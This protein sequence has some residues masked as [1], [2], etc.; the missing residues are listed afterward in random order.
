MLISFVPTIAVEMIDT[1]LKEGGAK[2]FQAPYK[3]TRFGVCGLLDIS[4]FTKMSQTFGNIGSVGTEQ[5]IKVL[6][7]YFNQLIETLMEIDCD[8]LKFAGDALLLYWPCGQD[9]IKEAVANATFQLISICEKTETFSPATENNVLAASDSSERRGLLEQTI[10]LFCHAG[11]TVGD[12]TFHIL[13]GLHDRHEF[14]VSSP[15]LTTEIAD[16][17]EKSKVREVVV[18]P[19]AWE[20]IAHLCDF[21]ERGEGYHLVKKIDWKCKKIDGAV[22]ETNLS[23]PRAFALVRTFVPLPMHSFLDYEE[24]NVL[25]EFRDIVVLF[26]GFNPTGSLQDL[27]YNVQEVREMCGT[28]IIL[29]PS[30]LPS[31]HL[32]SL[33]SPKLTHN[34][35][36]SAPSVRRPSPV[37]TPLALSQT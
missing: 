28:P 15:V 6:N 12:L 21:E 8:I 27:F 19:S 34:L 29:S 10:Q 4:G 16:S 37:G 5:I 25:G 17:V 35:T 30:P 18:G 13:G 9:T 26:A 31:F 36:F 7:R 20:P 33:P 32:L 22:T 2:P 24:K 3:D 1:A 14:V 23:D 11:L